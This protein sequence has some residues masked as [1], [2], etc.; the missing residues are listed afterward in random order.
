VDTACSSAMVATHLARQHLATAG[1][2]ALAAGVNLM[3]AETTTAAAHAAGMLTPDGRCKALDASADGYVRSEACVVLL[4]TAPA[5]ANGL[6]ASGS[7]GGGGQQA[8]SYNGAVLRTSYVNQDGRSSSLTAPNGPSQQQVNS[9]T[10]P[11][12]LPSQSC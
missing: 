11:R 7:E 2:C 6:D 1:G 8:D 3:L 9:T 10:H 4:L 12:G 5:A